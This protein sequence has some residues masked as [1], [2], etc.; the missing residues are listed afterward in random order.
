M[1]A[2]PALT[3]M[4]RAK[5]I[6]NQ[7][8][9]DPRKANIWV[10]HTFDGR[11]VVLLKDL[12]FDHFFFTEGDPNVRSADYDPPLCD[13]EV[14]GQLFQ[15]KFDA[16][17][18][19]ENGSIHSRHVRQISLKGAR[20][21]ASRL[22]SACQAAARS[23]GA[24]YEEVTAADLDSAHQ[25]II[26]WF[27][28]LAAYSRCRHRSLAVLEHVI[29]AR[30]DHAHEITIAQLLHWLPEEQPALVLGALASV[31]RKRVVC[32]DLDTETWG[33][34]SRLWRSEV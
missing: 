4:R 25:R 26:N 28:V 21:E 18:K 16:L 31:L 20:L 22:M 15:I 14:D 29:M 3:T 10:V 2:N 1:K 11:R 32:S 19:F 6:G 33:M 27:R 24:T 23:L 7:P 17:V 13:V 8:V 9:G 5:F 34:H 12:N 30:I